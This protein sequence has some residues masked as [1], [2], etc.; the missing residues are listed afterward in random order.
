MADCV[1][2]TEMSTKYGTQVTRTAASPKRFVVVFCGLTTAFVGA[3]MNQWLT[4]G[5]V[6]GGMFGV[7]LF[8]LTL[9]LLSLTWKPHV[10][11]GNESPLNISQRTDPVENLAEET[12][13]RTQVNGSE[14][15]ARR[16][17]RRYPCIPKAGNS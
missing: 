17:R 8:Y 4:G 12:G 1:V 2:E 10:S 9:S 15:A 3:V 5:I 6:M 14:T 16:Q 7:V 11:P 13:Y